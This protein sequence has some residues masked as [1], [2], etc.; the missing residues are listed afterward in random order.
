MSGNVWEWCADWYYEKEYAR[1][2][3]T[4]TRGNPQGPAD[5]EGYVVRGGA[6]DSSPKQARAAH[7]NWYYPFNRRMN[8]GFRL[9]AGPLVA[10]RANRES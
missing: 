8:V 9:A 3:R 4:L 6:F 7:R 1:R 5:G 2:A 10:G